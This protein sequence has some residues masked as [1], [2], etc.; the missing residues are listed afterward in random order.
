VSGLP[1]EVINT[2]GGTSSYGPYGNIHCAISDPLKF[3]ANFRAFGNTPAGHPTPG[4]P[5]STVIL[6][7]LNNVQ[8]EDYVI[9][10]SI[11]NPRFDLMDQVLLDFLNS[12]GA[13]VSNST[14]GPMI[15]AYKE[16]GINSN[17][18]ALSIGA[19]FSEVI[20]ARFQ[21]FGLWNSGFFTSTLIGPA[22]EWGSIHWRYSHLENPPTDNQ[23]IEVFGVT[24]G[25]FRNLLFTIPAQTLDTVISFIDAQTYPYLRMRFLSSDEVNRTPTQPKYWRVL[26]KEVPEIA[27]NPNLHYAVS[28]DT[29]SQGETW[30]VEVALEN[31][32]EWPMDS[33]WSKFST[34]FG[35]NSLERVYRQFDSLPGLDTINLHFKVNTLDNKHVGA[36][37]LTIEANPLDFNHQMEQ[38]HFNNFAQIR[39]YVK[40]DNQNPLLDV[41]FDGVH[42]LDGD[43]VSAKPE[44]SVLLKDE[45]KF[46]ALDDT[47]L[48]NIFFRYVPTGNMWRANYSD[49]NVNFF[50]ADPANLNES[51][52]ANVI[53]YAEFPQDGLY[54]LIIRSADKTGNTSSG[55]DN[56]LTG[57]VYY[58]Y[59][60]SFEVVNKPSIS[61]VLNYPNPFT[62]QTQFVFTLTGSELPDY[63]E[64]QIMNIKGTV[65]KQI[66]MDELGPIRIGLNRTQ[67]AWDGRDQYGDP[68][69]NGVYFYRI[70]TSLDNKEIDHYS[71]DQ[72]DKFFKKGIGKM[73]LIR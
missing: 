44:I 27:V 33:I 18:E 24:P 37:D 22:Q 20:S 34:R 62:T 17:V 58:D 8:P 54:E 2:S 10:Y 68:L 55:T 51:N 26:Y 59:K 9:I 38:F 1:R 57:L 30:N 28:A 66:R 64:I 56:R 31:V 45:N 43:L 41:T 47:S 35:D 73:V 5:W 32:T 11:N 42:I 50:P 36:N 46:L 3:V 40:G 67:Y 12:R 49:V 16:N 53:I 14:S 71:I 69:A 48:I 15:L 7:Y 60:I 61:N 70:I 72:V 23:S 13:P 65:V 39:Y 52:K 63:M 6:N 25:G 29:V 21:I 19:S 4:I